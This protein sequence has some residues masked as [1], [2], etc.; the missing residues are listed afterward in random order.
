M[1]QLLLTSLLL[2]TIAVFSYSLAHAAE[3]SSD[4]FEPIFMLPIIIPL[5][6]EPTE[7]KEPQVNNF[8]LPIESAPNKKP[9]QLLNKMLKPF[10]QEFMT[11]PDGP[12]ATHEIIPT[13]RNQLID[14]KLQRA[15]SK[16]AN[17]SPTQLKTT[18]EFLLARSNKG[19][20]DDQ[21]ALP[22]FMELVIATHQKQYLQF[23][24]QKYREIAPRGNLDANSAALLAAA[25]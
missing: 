7:M 1:N 23:K 5:A 10:F 18:Y 2:V 21:E 12:I 17:M 24:Q 20:I 4:E 13:Q 9:E 11:D 19:S 6:I 22:L 15:T 8:P 16:I 14:L 25:N 3:M